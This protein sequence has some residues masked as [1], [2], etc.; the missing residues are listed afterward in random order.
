MAWSLTDRAAVPPG[1]VSRELEGETVLLNL[2]TGTYYGLDAVG[3]DMWRA[4]RDTATL[5]DALRAVRFGYDVDE[6]T[7]RTDFLQLA[8][9]LLAKGLLQRSGE[10]SSNG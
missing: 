8:E 6:E 10:P 5:G 9:E 3:T 7:I 1:V 4:I 2:D